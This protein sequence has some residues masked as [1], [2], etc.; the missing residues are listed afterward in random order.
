MTRWEVMLPGHLSESQEDR[1]RSGLE[2]L[3]RRLGM[4]GVLKS[5][6]GHADGGD[7]EAGR[8]SMDRLI[9]FSRK[10]MRL[11]E[12][13]NWRESREDQESEASWDRDVEF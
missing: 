9:K 5:R 7:V 1:L 4:M 3:E 6:P 8:S 11:G 2:R 10:G 13:W 12:I